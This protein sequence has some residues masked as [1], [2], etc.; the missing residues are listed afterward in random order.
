MQYCLQDFPLVRTRALQAPGALYS[1]EFK[2]L[3]SKVP[4]TV[5]HWAWNPFI[6][7]QT[8]ASW[9]P[10]G[11][12]LQVVFGATTCYTETVLVYLFLITVLQVLDLLDFFMV[13]LS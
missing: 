9:V 13:F 11:I 7:L 6:F 12:V 4:I 1:L 5:G 2:M 10:T 8:L 3:L